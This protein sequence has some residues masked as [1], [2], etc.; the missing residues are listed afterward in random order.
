M[1]IYLS[2]YR[3]GRRSSLLQRTGGRGLIVM[4]ALDEYEQRMPSW[5]REV[6]D[7]ARLGYLSEELGLRSPR[8]CRRG[9]PQQPIFAAAASTSLSSQ[10]VKT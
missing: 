2:S 9:A 8:R 4:N 7:L 6:E 1:R 3:L 5:D 10:T